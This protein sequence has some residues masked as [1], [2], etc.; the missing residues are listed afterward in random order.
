LSID[1]DAYCR[2]IGFTGKRA[3]TLETLRAVHRLQ[4]EAI[5]FENLDP[6]LKRPVRLDVASLEQKML[7]DGRGGYCFEQNLL[8]SHALKAIGFKVSEHTGRVRW[9]L[10]KDVVTPRMHMVLVVEAEGQN[11]LADVG[12]GGNTLTGPL[13]MSSRDEQATPHEPARLIDEGD[14]LVAQV[15]IRDAWASLYAFDLTEQMLPDLEL[16]N[17]YTSAHPSSRFVNELIA[18]RVL[19]DGRYALLNNQLARHRLG[20][21]TERRSLHSVPELRDALT[22]IFRLKLPECSELDTV[23]ARFTNGAA[24]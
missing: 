11:Y 15:K 18:M 8:L 19:P 20:R 1:L 13:L 2:R 4:P 16:S 12:F 24:P 3:A 9:N 6:L 21:D 7:Q 5:A 14:W 10:A 22:D 17:W 23:L